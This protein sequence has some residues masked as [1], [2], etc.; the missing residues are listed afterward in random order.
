MLS[1]AETE[2]GAAVAASRLA[3]ALIDAGQRVT[4]LVALPDGKEHSWETRSLT[5]S[6]D[7]LSGKIFRRLLPESDCRILDERRVHQRLNSMLAELSPDIINVHNLHK[8]TDKHWTPKVVS[9]CAQHAPTVWTLHDMW[10]FTGRCAYSYDCTKYLT[11]C[12]S[13]CPTPEEHPPLAPARIAGAWT[14]RRLELRNNPSIVAVTPSN[15]LALEARRGLWLDHRV[16]VIPYGVPLDA[17][18]PVDRDEARQAIGIATRNPVLLMV[19]EFLEDR[20]KG[21]EILQHA[22]QKLSRP[23]TVIT[24]GNGRLNLSPKDIHLHELG[25]VEEERLKRMAYNTADVFVHPAP[26]D[27]YPNV[28]MEAIACGTPV[29][30]FAIGGLPDM[31]R[32]GRT[33][34][35]CDSVSSGALAATLEAALKHLAC[36]IELRDTCRAVAE[37]EF[38]ASLQSQRYL[39]LY[40]S[41]VSEHQHEYVGERVA[42]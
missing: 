34:W 38:G 11:G 14:T 39:D 29:V 35:L 31:V 17:Y 42:V 4:R 20:R 28:V 32:P 30:A 33:G 21:A 25:F 26:V 3:Q 5:L 18:F 15:W 19:A 40:L 2:G 27:N 41:L 10:S 8:A 24:L 22:L 7:G 23:V 9:S 36:G 13:A 37:T 12:D 6:A 16:E 1:D